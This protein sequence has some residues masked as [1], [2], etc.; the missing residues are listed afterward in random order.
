MTQQFE[1]LDSIEQMVISGFFDS[2]GLY[3]K[4]SDSQV[5]LA[6]EWLKLIDM[7][8]D[9]NQPFRFFPAGHQRMILIAR[10]MVKHPPL[11][12]LDEPVSGL[13]DEMAALFTA[14]IHKIAGRKQHRHPVRIT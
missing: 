9:K 3:I 5:Q 12:I 14:L 4:P 8:S 1:R 2:V 6:R 7:Y 11:L 10:A 13:D